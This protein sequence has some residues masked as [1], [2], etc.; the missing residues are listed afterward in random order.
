MPMKLQFLGCGSY[1]SDYGNNNMV[2]EINRRR[3]LI[4]C[5]FTLRESLVTAR[6]KPNDFDAIF[7]SHQ[8][9]DHIHGLEYIVTYSLSCP[10]LIP[11][12]R[13]IR[14]FLPK[15]LVPVVQTL[16]RPLSQRNEGM[17]GIDAFF[18]VTILD[19]TGFDWMGV[20]FDIDIMPHIRLPN[21]PEMV[22]HSLRFPAPS[23]EQVYITT[24][25]CAEVATASER[26]KIMAHF[27]QSARIYHDCETTARPSGVHTNIRTLAAYPADIR[28]KLV[29][30]HYTNPAMIREVLPGV[31]CVTRY[32]VYD[33]SKV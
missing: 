12:G 5:G 25:F 18:N 17:F 14:L 32:T 9:G 13:R 8:H 28:A 6:L 15:V 33:L 27:S 4:D 23:G 24:D 7:I 10:T 31:P 20:H 16:L 22:S 2:L 21:K 1:V 11:A 3:M 29:C 26:D 30:M 19:E